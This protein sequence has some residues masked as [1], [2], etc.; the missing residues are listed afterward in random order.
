M[1]AS[2]FLPLR[3]KHN[4]HCVGI[5]SITVRVFSLDSTGDGLGQKKKEKEK[6]GTGVMATSAWLLLGT[7]RA[8]APTLK[9]AIEK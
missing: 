6:E 1:A 7:S 9:V 5:V 8:R 3:V 2:R 4:T